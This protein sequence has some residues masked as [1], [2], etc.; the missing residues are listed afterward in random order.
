MYHEHLNLH[1][2][3]SLTLYLWGF[4]IHVQ[5]ICFFR[6]DFNTITLRY[7]NLNLLVTVDGNLFWYYLYL[8]KP[9]HENGEWI[10]YSK[11]VYNFYVL[12]TLIVFFK[13]LLIY[14]LWIYDTIYY[15]YFLGLSLSF[16]D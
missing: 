16:Y 4:E 3:K 1:L 13:C 12:F 9:V 2:Y 15:L 7:L 8:N 5:W 10:I 11:D 6:L 14:V